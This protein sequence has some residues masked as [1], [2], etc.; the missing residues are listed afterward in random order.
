[1]PCLEVIVDAPL[2]L[3]A[4]DDRSIQ[5]L[6]SHADDVMLIWAHGRDDG[7]HRRFGRRDMNTGDYFLI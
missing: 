2:L 7:P 5:T 3:D 1:M 4:I 6:M